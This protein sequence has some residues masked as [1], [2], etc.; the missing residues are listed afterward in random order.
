MKKIVLTFLLAISL[1]A[2]YVE[3]LKSYLLSKEFH[4]DG[5]FFLVQMDT[6]G[7]WIYAAL[8]SS[9]EVSGYYE[10]LGAKP[11]SSNPFG[12]KPLSHAVPIVESKMMG[13]FIYVGFKPDLKDPVRKAYSW[14]FVDA[15]SG[16]IYKLMGQK[17][18][19]FEYLQQDGAIKPLEGIYFHKEGSKAVFYS[20]ADSYEDSNLSIRKFSKQRGSIAYECKVGT[21]NPYRLF[22]PINPQ[23]VEVIDHI[24]GR[25]A[26]E[27]AVVNLTKKPLE[28]TIH[29][30]GAVGEKSVD[31]L[32]RYKPLPPQK[33]RSDWQLRYLANWSGD[34]V[35]EEQGNCEGVDRVLAKP[36]FVGF[37][38]TLT[39]KESNSSS[40]L[41]F[42]KDIYGF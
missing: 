34:S 32:R 40:S 27:R 17:N 39:I 11:S 42:W 7:K 24:E 22:S 5:T 29:I 38:R 30:Q 2:G 23:K 26:Y 31:C 6:T 36:L 8:D 9:G 1:M 35:I 28:G 4:I 13:Y 21:A 12:W 18:G 20:C 15:K 16:A 37:Q 33:I 25:V 10:L 41:V 19:Y 3:E 14:I